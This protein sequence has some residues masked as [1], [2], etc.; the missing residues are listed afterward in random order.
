NLRCTYCFYLEKAQMYPDTSRH[1]MSEPVLEA[2]VKQV[3]RGGMD[4]VNFG[5]QGGEPTLMGLDFYKQAVELQQRH[6]APGQS[7]GNSLQTNGVLLDEQWAAFLH[8][9]NWLIG[10]SLDGPE[11][12]H[13]RYRKSSGGEPTWK[14]VSGNARMLLANKV[15][16]NVLCLVNDLSA[17]HPEEIYDF[18]KSIGI[19]WMQFI[20]CVETLP[21]DPSTMAPYAVGP[22]AFGEFLCRIFDKWTK[23]FVNGVP[24]VYVRYFESVFHTYVGLPPPECTLLDE[25]GCY[26]VVEHNGDVYCCDFF[27]Q[28]DCHLGNVLQ[29]DLI[30]MLNGPR[31]KAFGMKKATLPPQC[32]AC[33][34]LVQC[35][36]GCL[37][38]RL[39][40]PCPDGVNY[41]CRAY[42]MFFEHTDA[43]YRELVR[44]WQLR[45]A[46]GVARPAAA[47]PQSAYAR[48]TRQA[49][50]RLDGAAAPARKPGR[51]ESCPCGS[52][53]KFKHCCGGNS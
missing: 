43:H 25:C 38:E 13:D 41:L 39:R 1:R 17:R 37:K 18:H 33:P 34:W 11:F 15:E 19:P 5:W 49:A 14:R 6:G 51:N 48:P 23:D 46:R 27:V 8:Q 44:Q 29:G 20:P 24:T 7:V 26:V 9:Y 4:A 12:I 40:V 53:R 52:G 32:Q 50:R 42:K 45:Q 2:M 47:P 35:R 3:L 22:E 10:L 21:N 16:T 28:P 36:G 31:Q 30:E